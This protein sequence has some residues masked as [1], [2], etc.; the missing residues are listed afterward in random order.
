MLISTD[1]IDDKNRQEQASTIEC[2]KGEQ[3]Y[4]NEVGEVL[5]H[6]AYGTRKADPRVTRIRV[7]LTTTAAAKQE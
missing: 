2:G 3:V 7:T 4:V 6:C 5:T 1:R